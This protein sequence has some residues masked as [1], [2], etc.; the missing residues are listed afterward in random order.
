MSYWYHQTTKQY[1]I[2]V[3]KLFSNIHVKRKDAEGTEL[4]DVKVPLMYA[5]KRKLTNQLQHNLEAD[6]VSVIYPAMAFYITS[7]EMSPQRK[8][9]TSNEIVVDENRYVYEA[10]PYDY[11]F[12]VTIQT[13][14]QDD[15]WQIVEQVLY[16]FKPD[17]S[18]DIIELPELG[19]TRDVLI[20]LEGFDIETPEELDADAESSRYFEATLS[21]NLQGAI[22]PPVKDNVFIYDVIANVRDNH[23]HV[24]DGDDD[25]FFTAIESWDETSEEFSS[26]IIEY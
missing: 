19:I 10:V 26:E 9:S 18:L 23:D 6:G 13:K 14:Y 25:K 2:A 3:S 22:Y 24:P 4:K 12:E 16:Y 20:T 5:T 17:I 21:L 11:N 1:I 15:F 8:L 7:L